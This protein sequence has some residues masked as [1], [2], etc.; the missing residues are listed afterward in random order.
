MKE[1]AGSK[2]KESQSSAIAWV[3]KNRNEMNAVFTVH[4]RLTHIKRSVLAKLS[5][6]ESDVSTFVKS[7]NGYKVTAPEGF[8]AIDR[9]SNSA[10]KLVDRLE[11]SKSNFNRNI[12]R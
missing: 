7:G 9:L 3:E 2:I 8:V 12:N 5:A 10:L 4:S 6:I 11:F 1:K